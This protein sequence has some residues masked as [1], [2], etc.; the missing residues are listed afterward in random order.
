MIN[1]PKDAKCDYYGESKLVKKRIKQLEKTL[2]QLGV[3]KKDEPIIITNYQYGEELF[4]F[5]F[6]VKDLQNTIFTFYDFKVRNT[7]VDSFKKNYL[8][9][10]KRENSNFY[11]TYN[12]NEIEY[13]NYKQGIRMLE[14]S[15]PLS[16]NRIIKLEN[17]LNRPIRLMIEEE[18]KKYILYF[19]S[20]NEQQEPMML[21]SFKKLISKALNLEKI[22]LDNILNLIENR[23]KIISACIIEKDKILASIDFLGLN[24]YK[25]EINDQNKKIEVIFKNEVTRSVTQ[26]FDDKIIQY[27]EEITGDNCVKLKSD[28]KK[29]FKQL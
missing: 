16:E 21:E 7:D 3:F 27:N 10:M 17:E 29:L 24:I 8:L 12:F 11:Y 25:Y 14:V 19:N 13:E 22:N 5:I 20:P 6:E 1:F 9:T 26:N 2:R 28:Y 4:D 18:A 23:R 15:Y